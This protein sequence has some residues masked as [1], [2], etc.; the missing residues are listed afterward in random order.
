MVLYQVMIVD[1]CFMIY[2]GIITVWED[3]CSGLTWITLAHEFIF[4]YASICVVFIKIAL[5]TLLTK[6]S[7]NKPGKFTYERT[8]APTNENDSTVFLHI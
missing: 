6:L 7:P 5:I 3:Q 2:C 4:P 1:N 8:L